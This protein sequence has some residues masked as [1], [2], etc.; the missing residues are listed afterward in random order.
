MNW[1][2]VN[3]T[4]NI[5]LVALVLG[6][7]AYYFYK[8]PKYESG[9]P[10]KE[11]V[12]NL[13]TKEPF[14]LSDLRGQYV[15]IDFWGSWCGPCRQENPLLLQLFIEMR[16][17]KFVNAG[18]FEIVSIALENDPRQWSAAVERDRLIW[19]YHIVELQRFSGPIATLYGVKEIPTKYLINPEGLIIKVN[20]TVDEIR[21]YLLEKEAK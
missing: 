14:K 7:V 15:L 11:I 12:T 1:K 18:G 8:Q 3:K 21:T 4:L 17:K 5:L 2:P 9:E 20:P 13:V 10:A 16:N 19:K 6:Y